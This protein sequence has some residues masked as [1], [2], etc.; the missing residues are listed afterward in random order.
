LVADLNARPMRLYRASRR[1][2]FER[3][4]QPALRP[5]PAEPFVYG[6]WKT[7]RVNVDYHVEL[8]GHYYSVPYALVHEAVDVRASV[9]TVEIFHRGQ[10]V[11]AHRRTDSRGRHTTDPAHMPK[12]HQRHL[13]WTPSRLIDW[14]RTIGPHTAALVQAILADRPHPEQGYRSCLGLLRLAKHYGPERLEAA[15]ARAGAVEARSY[16]HVDSILKHGLD[17]LAGPEA[18]PPLPLTPVHEHLRGRDYY[19]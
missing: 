18:A 8:H 19:Q 2:L 7:A 15:C 14:A 12:A 11:G 10:R 9:S 3:L 17:R 13:E 5:L 16:R 6:E 1:E 4:D